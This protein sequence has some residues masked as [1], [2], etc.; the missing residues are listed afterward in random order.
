MM[1]I[2][3]YILWDNYWPQMKFGA[4]QVFYT[5]V[6]FC[7]QEGWIPSM[8][9]M[10]RGS[11]SGGEGLVRDTHPTWMHYCSFYFGNDFKFTRYNMNL[12]LKGYVNLL[13]IY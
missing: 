7:S 8:H 13:F 2:F 11:A 4:R 1:L 10:T 12:T 3:G 5:C 9:H 6:S